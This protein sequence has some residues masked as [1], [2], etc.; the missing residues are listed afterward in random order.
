MLKLVFSSSVSPKI[1]FLMQRP[2]LLASLPQ[3][4]SL[5]VNFLVLDSGTRLQWYPLL[6]QL[7]P[8]TVTRREK[9][10]VLKKRNCQLCP[11]LAR[12]PRKKQVC[13]GRVSGRWALAAGEAR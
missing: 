5:P 8:Q 4:S 2:I 12:A 1:V 11:S 9:M 6:D 13:G 3:E 7:F 10:R